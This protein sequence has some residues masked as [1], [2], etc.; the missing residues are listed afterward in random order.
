MNTPRKNVM[1]TE[2]RIEIGKR[3]LESGSSAKDIASLTNVSL[4]SAQKFVS[5][6]FE[7][8]NFSVSKPGPKPKQKDALKTAIQRILTSDSSLPLS[9]IND[10]L[11]EALKTSN[12]SISRAL[13]DLGWSKKRIKTIPMERN[14]ARVLEER[15]QCVA[16]I[17]M[18]PNQDLIF[19][20][21]TGFNL[22]CAPKYGWSPLNT[23][24]TVNVPANRGKNIS[25]LATISHEGILNYEVFEG[26]VDSRIMFEVLSQKILPKLT[27]NS[28]VI[29][30]NARIHKTNTIKDL[31][32]QRNIPCMYLPPYSPQLNPIE[33]VFGMVKEKYRKHRPIPTNK[34]EMIRVIRQIFDSLASY[35]LSSFYIKMRSQFRG[36]L[37]LEPL[38]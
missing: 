33:E 7:K 16:Q 27:W 8:G 12:S 3:L 36:C 2:E 4:R 22:H 24:P 9:M 17:S 18:R 10:R 34:D 26:S 14:S 29:M 19:L 31:F 6:Y 30:D 32:R 1:W 11:P 13:K 15:K 37:N 5:E 21:E 28:I 25:V 20:D 23:V 38:L 35:D